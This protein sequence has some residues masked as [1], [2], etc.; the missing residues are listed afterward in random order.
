[1]TLLTR[2][3]P[4]AS[5]VKHWWLLAVRLSG[6]LVRFLRQLEGFGRMFHRLLGMFVSGQM[7]LFA[8]MHSSC[9]VGVRS[10]VM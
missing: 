2:G 6:L 4:A 10:Q 9:A 7:I 8:V 1:M 3:T 5:T